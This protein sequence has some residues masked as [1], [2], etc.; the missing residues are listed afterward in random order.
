MTRRTPEEISRMAAMRLPE[1]SPVPAPPPKRH[2]S[3]DTHSHGMAEVRMLEDA[4]KAL[5]KENANLRRQNL[6]LRCLA[7]HGIIY[8]LESLA[9]PHGVLGSVPACTARR[10]GGVQCGAN[11]ARK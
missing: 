7:I 1:K 6:Y 4:N 3:V 10:T 5:R 2:Y 11:S 8:R 9:G